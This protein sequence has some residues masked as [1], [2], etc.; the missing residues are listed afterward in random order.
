MLASQVI[1]S[2]GVRIAWIQTLALPLTTCA[3][4]EGRATAF[5][6]PQAFFEE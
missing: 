1:V 3:T 4:S 5:L 6:V 2:S